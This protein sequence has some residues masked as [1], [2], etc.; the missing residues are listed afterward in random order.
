MG[1]DVWIKEGKQK[2]RQHVNAITVFQEFRYEGQ[3][4]GKCNKEGFF[5]FFITPQMNLS[6]LLCLPL[7]RK[8]FPTR[9]ILHLPAD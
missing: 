1:K 9:S 8:S 2:K 3:N 5:L 7:R 4:G 6:R